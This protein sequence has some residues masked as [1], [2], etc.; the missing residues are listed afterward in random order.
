MLLHQITDDI[1]MFN[2]KIGYSVD[3]RLIRQLKDEH[4]LIEQLLY[5]INDAINSAS[6]AMLNDYIYDFSI[7]LRE[8][9]AKENTKFYMRLQYVVPHNSA[10]LHIVREFKEEMLVIGR[11]I[12]RFVGKYAHR[13]INDEN[14]RQFSEDFKSMQLILKKRIHQEESK[15]FPLYL[16]PGE[17]HR[18]DKLLLSEI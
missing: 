16:D 8:H 6:F 18:Y 2:S 13:K 4:A 14:G 1:S 15:L 5:N 10:Q 12:N 9:F 7:L 17:Q 3:V 11:D